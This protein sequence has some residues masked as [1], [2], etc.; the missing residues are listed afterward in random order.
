[1]YLALNKEI[2]TENHTCF[3]ESDKYVICWEGL[4][5]VKGIPSGEDSVHF[6]LKKVSNTGISEACKS[7]SGNFSCIL[8]DKSSNN[9]YAFIDNDGLSLIFYNNLAISTSFLNLINRANVTLNDLNPYSV[10]EFIH[11]GWIFGNTAL[12]DSIQILPPDQI[13]TF[14]QHGTELMSKGIEKVYPCSSPEKTFLQTFGDIAIALQ[15][16]KIR[17]HLTGGTD[18]R[19]LALLF[20]K[21]GLNFETTTMGPPGHPDVEIASKLAELLGLNHHVECP[22]VGEEQSVLEELDEIFEVSDGLCD[23]FRLYQYGYHLHKRRKHRGVD[24]V[25]T[26]NGG[27]LYKFAGWWTFKK[28]KR[29]TTIER[30]AP[31]MVNWYSGRQIP[32]DFF[33]DHFRQFASIYRSWLVR[34]L[35]IKFTKDRGKN[36]ADKIFFEY[37]VRG[38]YRTQTNGRREKVYAPLLDRQLVA[39]AL[40]IPSYDRFFSN[41][42]RKLI[43]SL[44]RDA[45]QIETTDHRYGYLK[46]LHW[47]LSRK[48]KGKLQR[49]NKLIGA[50]HKPR[51]QTIN[52]CR[53]NL[54]EVVKGSKN[55]RENVEY[56]RTCGILRPKIHIEEIDDVFFGRLFSLA[57]LFKRLGT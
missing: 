21:E 16:N 28:E 14:S 7:L 5:F 54:Y 43:S 12:F 4:I 1:M 34:N 22:T 29:E 15:N 3:V 42:H 49:L 57:E 30:L 39:C 36:L 6:F 10:I 38:A 13:L 51:V 47:L 56:L 41:F 19:L 2:L 52:C 8:C 45:S 24:L 31:G 18:T 23:I 27:E 11:S 46:G 9:Y 37:S 55:G 35:S 48:V 33:T 44:N 32:Y 53:C 25:V 50:S 20:K 40:A 17:L 26:G